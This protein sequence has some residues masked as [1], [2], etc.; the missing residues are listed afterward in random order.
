[1]KFRFPLINWNL[2]V[3]L[4]ALAFASGCA[5]N[6]EKKEKE[7][8]TIRLHFE[9]NPQM[10]RRSMEVSI[11]RAHPMK[12]TVSEEAL[13][14]EGYLDEVALLNEGSTHQLRLRFDDGGRRLL[15]TETAVNIG[16]RIA[17]AA[18]FPNP[19]WLGAPVIT[20]I[21]TNG[22]FTFTPD[23]DLEECRQLVDG[24]KRAIEQR[25]KN[26]WIK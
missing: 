23:A 5:S 3:L 1:M 18:Q 14:H 26:T 17:V 20:R 4:G 22:V 10:V 19:R 9:V 6:G 13:V 15:E 24:L 8:S 2:T 11:L 25:Q 16:K 7:I 12:L 21:N